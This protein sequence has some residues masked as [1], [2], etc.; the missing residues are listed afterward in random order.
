MLEREL[1]KRV[2]TNLADAHWVRVESPGTPGV[3]DLNGCLRGVEIWVELKVVRGRKVALRPAQVAWM[4]SRGRAGGRSWIVARVERTE[5]IWIWP[6][7]EALEV[8][9]R[10]LDV[11][12]LLRVAK[13]YPWSAVRNLLFG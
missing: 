4:V 11:E 9:S 7:C 8:A 2:K 12:P 13:P 3:P 1:W 10:G 5:E 6:G